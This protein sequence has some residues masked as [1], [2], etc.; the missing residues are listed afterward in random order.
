MQSVPTGPEIFV[1]F[2]AKSGALS[3]AYVNGSKDSDA[4]KDVGALKIVK[5]L[6]SD[7]NE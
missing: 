4:S 7:A 5:L 3:H 1:P 2:R 6:S